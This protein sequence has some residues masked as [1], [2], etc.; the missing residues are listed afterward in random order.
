LDTTT[1][2]MAFDSSQYANHG[3]LKDMPNAVWVKENSKMHLALVNPVLPVKYLCPMHRRY[4]STII[5][6]PFPFG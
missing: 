6:L 2:T 1:G 4:G 3:I 5:R